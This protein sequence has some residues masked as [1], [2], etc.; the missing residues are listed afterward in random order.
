M[1][2]IRNTKKE[3]RY[4]CGDLASELLIAS[5]AIKGFDKSVTR[6]IIGEIASMQVDALSKCSFAFD[7]AHSDFENGKAYREAHSKYVAAAFRKLKK[8]MAEKTQAIV[9]RMN[10]AMPQHIKDAAQK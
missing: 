6:Q 1:A 9:D 10:A 3:I 7:R 5:H 8:E 2:S 4:A